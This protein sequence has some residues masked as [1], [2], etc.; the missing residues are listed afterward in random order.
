MNR[1]TAYIRKIEFIENL[2]LVTLEADAHTLTI[3][4]LELDKSFQI[5]QKVQL[6]IKSTNISIAKDFMGKFSDSNQ[7]DATITAIN[8]G[9]LLC[10]VKLKSYSNN[11]EVL[12]TR[13]AYNS[14][15]IRNQ[16]NVTLL[17]RAHDISIVGLAE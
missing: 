5:A 11:F 2:H 13:D 12:I 6:C 9:H 3:L 10:S 15:K 1:L 8:A 16:D 4:T 17:V 7:I 14:M